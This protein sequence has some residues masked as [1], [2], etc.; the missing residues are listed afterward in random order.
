[1]SGE[2][3]LWAELLPELQGEVRQRLSVLEARMLGLT[4]KSEHATAKKRVLSMSRLFRLAAKRGYLGLCQ[5][6][7]AITATWKGYPQYLTYL[8]ALKGGHFDISAWARE[9]G[10]SF[11]ANSIFPGDEVYFAA[12]YGD[13]DGLRRYAERGLMMPKYIPTHCPFPVVRY[14]AEVHGKVPPHPSIYCELREYLP[15]DEE[16]IL[17]L[18]G[19]RGVRL[20][21]TV[22]ELACAEARWPIVNFYVKHAADVVAAVTR[23]YP[24][25][26]DLIVKQ[27]KLDDGCVIDLKT[28]EVRDIW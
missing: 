24:L 19:L 3:P 4:C 15:G 26:A 7:A 13:M 16:R 6:I 2:F 10:L 12:V 27:P 21:P 9:V 11:C 17:Y 25:V 22:F 8:E 1:M 5:W 23:D 18:M 28:G 20:V 14:L